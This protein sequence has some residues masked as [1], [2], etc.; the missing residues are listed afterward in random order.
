MNIREYRRAKGYTQ[1]KASYLLNITDK[2]LSKI[3]TGKRAPSDRLRSKM[4]EVY[5]VNIEEIFL[6][7]NRT[8]SS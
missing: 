6:L 1:K 5:E 7:T 8:K 2:Y 3:E 4:A